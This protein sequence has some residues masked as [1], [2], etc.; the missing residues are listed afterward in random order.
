M[1]GRTHTA[2]YL[3][4]FLEKCTVKDLPGLRK[5]RLSVIGRERPDVFRMV[6]QL[7]RAGHLCCVF[8]NT[9]E[10]HWDKLSSRRYYPSLAI[11][12][13]VFPSHL[14]AHA[15]PRLD[16]FAFVAKA[17]N[18][19]M[20]DCLLIDDTPLNVARAKAAGWRALTFANAPKL[21]AE[22]AAALA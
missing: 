13:R 9:I 11:F 15:K 5:N 14:I 3:E 7:K 6:H 2:E 21:E 18:R 10:L 1:I 17:L 19:R 4:A 22:L 16:A 20:P 12:D 8:S